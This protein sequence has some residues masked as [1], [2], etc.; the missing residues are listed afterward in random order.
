[1]S[2]KDPTS[3]FI[4]K[5]A[6]DGLID[7]GEAATA[8][9]TLAAGPLAQKGIPMLGTYLAKSLGENPVK[10]TGTP[11]YGL[12]RVGDILDEGVNLNQQHGIL[13]LFKARL[14]P[15]GPGGQLKQVPSELYQLGRIKDVV[16]SMLE[17]YK[18][19]QKGV[20][21]D[22]GGGPLKAITGP[23]YRPSNKLI[24]LPWINEASVL[25][26]VG[27]AAHMAR[28][29]AGAFNTI[30]KII[31]KGTN[32]AIPMAY[33]AGDEIQK[34]FPGKIDDKAV[35]FV[36]DN[37]PSIMAA[38][39]AAAEVYPE[40][41]ATTRAV[42]HV[43]KTK[44]SAAARQ[45]LKALMPHL[46]SYVLPIVPAIVGV[47]LARNYFRK[48][49]AKNEKTQEKQAGILDKATTFISKEIPQFAADAWKELQPI[50]QEAG[51][52]GGQV[53]AQAGYLFDK[54]LGEFAKTLWDA[55]AKTIK[56]PEFIGGA[57][58][59]GVPAAALAYVHHNTQHG[60][61]HRERIREL[62]SKRGAKVKALMDMQR[63]EDKSHHD[64]VTWP[65]IVGITA[66]LSGGFLAKT[67]SDLFRIL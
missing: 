4:S 51:F 63:V 45:T 31:Q 32:L 27:H 33:I 1:M 9:F 21:L 22:V 40:V 52:V 41:Q 15:R 66:A 3:F 38:S 64:S 47:S 53:S 49:K 13:D 5:I 56:S 36:Q 19:P 54:P 58:H 18:L 17:R 67:F 37:A 20:K 44:G 57:V 6:E 26:E 39:W 30:R 43:Y 59:A 23:S 10:W 48:A 34:L 16:D 8:G 55:G 42:H 60:K 28:P 25:H 61:V 29:G 14:K 7:P 2:S 50:G 12:S 65:A 35:K 62:K 11:V 24:Q 46:I